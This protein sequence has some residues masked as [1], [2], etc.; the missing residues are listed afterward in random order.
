[1]AVKFGT[2]R[3]LLPRAI[4]GTIGASSAYLIWRP[5]SLFSLGERYRRIGGCPHLSRRPPPYASKS[6]PPPAFKPPPVSFRGAVKRWNQPW[7][8]VSGA[9]PPVAARV[10]LGNGKRKRQSSAVRCGRFLFPPP[11]LPTREEALYR[12][13]PPSILC[14]GKSKP[15]KYARGPRG[16]PRRS[17]G[18]GAKKR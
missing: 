10:A 6:A 8:G 14:Q 17:D 12:A 7:P 4:M 9:P 2:P 3:P 13:E 18:S 16:G 5:T 11:L 15:R 1:M